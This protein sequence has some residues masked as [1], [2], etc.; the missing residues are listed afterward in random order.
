MNDTK[1]KLIRK[2]PDGPRLFELWIGIL[3]LAMKSGR[4][5]MLEIGDGIPF[6]DETLSI[7]LDIAIPIVRL[8]LE[9][10]AKLKMIERFDNEEIYLTNFEKHQ[11]LERIEHNNRLNR[12]RVKKHRNKIK[13]VM[14]TPPLRNDEDTPA[15]LDLDKDLDK[16][17]KHKYGEY[18]H[19]LLTDEQYKKIQEKTGDIKKWV[20]DLDEGI[21]I[22][23]YKY[24]NHYLVILKWYAKA[25]PKPNAHIKNKTCPVCNQI[26]TGPRCQCGWMED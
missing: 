9:T 12:E 16:D 18:K 19:V 4:V 22:H 1:I 21:E 20:K 26:I 13:S 3:C 2:M 5:G 14:I 15:D 8:G 25:N 7:E 11:K 17:M 24:S 10:F 6:T 23:K